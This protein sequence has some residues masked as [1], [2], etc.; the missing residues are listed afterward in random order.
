MFQSDIGL[1]HLG[2]SILVLPTHNFLLR[3]RLL[4]HGVES[5]RERFKV[6]I[7]NL[8][9]HAGVSKWRS[10]FCLEKS[11]RHK[12]C[13]TNGWYDSPGSPKAGTRRRKPKP[14]CKS[15]CV[16]KLPLWGCHACGLQTKPP[17]L[18][19]THCALCFFSHFSFFYYLLHAVRKYYIALTD[20]HAIFTFADFSFGRLSILKLN[21]IEV[22]P[23]KDSIKY[24]SNIILFIMT[25]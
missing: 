6:M 11:P 21:S 14:S 16:A 7:H 1:L 25:Q 3:L 19:V 17:K 4:W 10:L 13:E 5:A 15:S 8:G 12:K 24:V 9:P 2:K 18:A 23:L 22:N 20:L